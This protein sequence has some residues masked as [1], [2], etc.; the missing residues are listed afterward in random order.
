[1][2]PDGDDSRTIFAKLIKALSPYADD[3]VLIGGWVH[4]LYLA[5]AN[6]AGERPS[7]W[8]IHTDDIDFAIPPTLLRA[9]R[10][11]LVELAL[12]AGFEFDASSVYDQT[13]ESPALFH[14]LK[15][16]VVDLDF[17][18]QAD[19][20]DVA[21]PIEG[22]PDLVTHGYPDLHILTLHTQWLEIGTDLHP[23]LD[24]AVRIRV[25]VPGA[26]VLQKG[27][28]SQ[29][30]T[31]TMK[32]AKDLVYL[33]ELVRHPGLS[34]EV[35]RQLP[36]VARQHPEEFRSWA[37]YL[38]GLRAD[39]PPVSDVVEQLLEANRAQGTM[40]AVGAQVASRIRRLVGETQGELQAHAD[41]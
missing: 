27:L 20:P 18:T 36:D 31:S 2:T 33:Y 7:Q 40:S 12:E 1:M 35:A 15:D 26:Y 28:A 29:R 24:P 21:I 11:T 25:P 37:T 5:D 10:A 23:A 13:E 17:L 4:A 22:Q 8:P 38:G 39:R 19:R 30:R 3:I 41:D 16:G 14:K 32:A 6:K 34:A 9:G